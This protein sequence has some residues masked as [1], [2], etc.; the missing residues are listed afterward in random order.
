M[1]K[2]LFIYI[3]VFIPLSVLSQKS[4]P[5][6]VFNKSFCLQVDLPGLLLFESTTT[7]AAKP[8]LKY[9]PTINVSFGYMLKK[10]FQKKFKKT[11][12]INYLQYNSIQYANAFN[13]ITSYTSTY[14]H[15]THYSVSSELKIL[16]DKNLKRRG[17]F[18]MLGAGYSQQKVYGD[19]SKLYENKM[20]WNIIVNAGYRLSKKYFY[21]E[22]NAGINSFFVSKANN[23]KLNQGNLSEEEYYNWQQANFPNHSLETVKFKDQNTVTLLYKMGG[24]TNS[25]LLPIIGIN[26]G[27]CF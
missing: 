24:L 20:G 7:S 4:I 27:F 15:L 12:L 2:K 9:S 11:I 23:Y 6:S 26:L 18:G 1:T 22:F 13:K 25:E 5:D 21:F 17:F 8:E 10:D 3:L 14:N 19:N 16:Y